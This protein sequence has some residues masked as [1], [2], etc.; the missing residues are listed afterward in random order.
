MTIKHNHQITQ[1]SFY[2]AKTDFVFYALSRTS[3]THVLS[4][5]C[6]LMCI[7]KYLYFTY[8]LITYLKI[9]IS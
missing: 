4:P 8:L 9:K 3:M 1:I 2:G 7:F 6:K 5:S